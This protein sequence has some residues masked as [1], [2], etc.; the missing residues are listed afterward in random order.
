MATVGQQRYGGLTPAQSQVNS[1]TWDPLRISLNVALGRLQRRTIWGRP[2]TS[3]YEARASALE[4]S[5]FQ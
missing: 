4:R 5:S 1:R 3:H 2:E